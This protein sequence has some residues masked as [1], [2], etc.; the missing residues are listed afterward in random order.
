MLSKLLVKEIKCKEILGGS[1]TG[2]NFN[3]PMFANS[4]RQ[5]PYCITDLKKITNMQYSPGALGQD[6]RSPGK[7]QSLSSKGQ[8]EDRVRI[9]IVLRMTASIGRCCAV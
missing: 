5:F 9:L 2:T 8:I 3:P 6:W 7:Q 1:G 4:D